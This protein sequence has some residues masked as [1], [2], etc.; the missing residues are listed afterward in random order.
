MAKPPRMTAPKIK[1]VAKPAPK[2]VAKPAPKPV[3]KPMSPSAV[4][5]RAERIQKMEAGESRLAKYQPPKNKPATPMVPSAD[6]A[7]TQATL[8]RAERIQGEEARGDALLMQ[9]KPV[10]V[11]RT[12]VRMK[13][14]PAKKK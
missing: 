9:R 12:T 7:R 5:G 2:P 3:A 4:L 10:D 11:I 6:R 13:E 8:S 14:T 1:P